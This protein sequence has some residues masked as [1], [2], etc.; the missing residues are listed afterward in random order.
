MGKGQIM[1]KNLYALNS[2]PM[3]KEELQR[4]W[5]QTI[6]LWK[7]ALEE[8]VALQEQLKDCQCKK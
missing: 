7:K 6:E 3:S 2:K 8:I 1:D 5:F 4:A